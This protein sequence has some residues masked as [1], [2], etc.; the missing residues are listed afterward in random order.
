[1]SSPYIAAPAVPTAL[2]RQSGSALERGRSV[3][4][5][6]LIALTAGAWLL[7]LGHAWTLETSA[8]GVHSAHTHLPAAF[9]D[10]AP[11]ASVGMTG[12]GWSAWGLLAFVVT[13]AVMMAAMMLPSAGPMLLLFHAVA[14]R[15][16]RH[17]SRLR[18]TWVFAGG[19]LAVWT[20]LGALVWAVVRLQSD[21]ASRLA[22]SDRASW[23][24]V[25]LGAV[26][27]A[28]GAYQFSPLKHHCLDQCRSPL[29]FLMQHWRPGSRGALHMG[30]V[31]GLYC[32]GC[33]AALCVCRWP[34]A[35]EPR[36]DA[37]A[38][39]CR[40]RREG[41]AARAADGRIVGFTF[42]VL[43]GVV[44]VHAVSATWLR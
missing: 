13:W 43:G 38:H 4:L 37:A 17:V 5:V 6:T 40:L 12:A 42:V 39:P 36:L 25:A 3:L 24:P 35:D 30:L 33:C 11:Y 8:G 31:H 7:T 41:P 32:L 23:A 21:L 28:A 14:G 18:P 34:W 16:Q 22:A 44:T 19:Y 20:A 10:G 15:P 26:L 29:V 2:P 1:M 9:A 27:V